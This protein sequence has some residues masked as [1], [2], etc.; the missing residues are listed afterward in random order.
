MLSRVDELTNDQHYQAQHIADL[1]PDITLM[2]A[3]A[4]AFAAMLRQRTVEAFDG[5][6]QRT[7]QSSLR[8]LRTFARGIQRDYNAVKAALELPFSNERVAY[9]TSFAF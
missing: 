1:H 4:Q 7:R 3:E 9:C 8:E 2:V 5:W 6:L